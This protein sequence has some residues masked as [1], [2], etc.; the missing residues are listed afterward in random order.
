MT[1]NEISAFTTRCNEIKSNIMS[2]KQAKSA[3]KIN[4][5][6]ETTIS[7]YEGDWIKENKNWLYTSKETWE[8]LYQKTL[9]EGLES[10][11]ESLL[12]VDTPYLIIKIL[13]LQVI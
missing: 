10:Q 8:K 11:G 7:Y 4:A 13:P 6:K 1:S 12:H 2:Y 3:K 5:T 9:D